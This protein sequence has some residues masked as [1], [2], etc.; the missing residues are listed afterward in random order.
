MGVMILAIFKTS[1][2]L[3][4]SNIEPACTYCFF[5]DVSSDGKM[6]LCDKKGIVSPYYSCNKFSYCPTKRIPKRQPSLPSFSKDDF[7]L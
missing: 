2:P 5:G 1:K 4:G 3:F 7:I 6:I